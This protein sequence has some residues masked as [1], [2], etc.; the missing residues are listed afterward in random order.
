MSSKQMFRGFVACQNNRYMRQDPNGPRFMS[1]PTFIDWF[2]AWG[3]RMKIDFRQRCSHCG[4]RIKTFACDGTKIGMNF[5]NNFMRLIETIE[6]QL[7]DVLPIRILNRCFLSNP[8]KCSKEV[9]ARCAQAG[10][11]LKLIPKSVLSDSFSLNDTIMFLLGSV[12]SVLA[13]AAIPAFEQMV[14]INNDIS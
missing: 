13:V 12:R 4:D 14:D 9:I 10:L 3:L 6:K 8:Q 2:F 5:K 1:L 7:G 11:N